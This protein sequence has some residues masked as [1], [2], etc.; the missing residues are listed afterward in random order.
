MLWFAGLG[1]TVDVM[2]CR[3]RRLSELVEKTVTKRGPVGGGNKYT[4]P[5][6]QLTRDCTVQYTRARREFSP[7]RIVFSA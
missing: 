7:V 6:T 3:R 4:G 5:L 2:I 1:R